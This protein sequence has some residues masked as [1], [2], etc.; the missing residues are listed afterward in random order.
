[1]IVVTVFLFNFERT[2]FYLVQNRKENCHHD[3]IPFNVKGNEN[4]VFSVQVLMYR[5]SWS[6]I[7]LVFGHAYNFYLSSGAVRARWKGNPSVPSG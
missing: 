5:E 1:M 2:E 6:E 3:H 7:V 4:L